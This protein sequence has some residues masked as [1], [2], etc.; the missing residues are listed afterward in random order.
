MKSRP[1]RRSAPARAWGSRTLFALSL[2]ASTSSAQPPAG[3]TRDSAPGQLV[4]AGSS[5][6]AAVPWTV[7]EQAQ[8]EVRFGKLKVGRG[9][10]EVVRLVHRRFLAK[11]MAGQIAPRESAALAAS[12]SEEPAR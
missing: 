6:R 10:I 2:L 4:T 5:E 8:Y 1:H 3:V 11:V 12:V 9:S 7:G